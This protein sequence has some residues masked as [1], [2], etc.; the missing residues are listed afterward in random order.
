M[1]PTFEAALEDLARVVIALEPLAG[2]YVLC[3]GFAAWAFQALPGVRRPDEALLDIDL[4]VA[5]RLADQPSLSELLLAAEFGALHDRG[6]EP[7]VMKG[8]RQAGQ[9]LRVHLRRPGPNTC[10][11][12]GDGSGSMLSHNIGSAPSGFGP[13]AR[14][15]SG[16]SVRPLPWARWRWFA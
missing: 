7:P 2:E 6:T 12:A 5:P 3:G 9:R 8:P 4:A 10:H 11:V 13:P 1:K 16:G 15:W 14:I